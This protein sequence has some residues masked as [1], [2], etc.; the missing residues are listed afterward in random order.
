[1]T[2]PKYTLRFWGARGTVPSP[3]AETLRYGGNTSCLALALDD[4]EHLILDCGSGVR[5]FGMTLP[6]R[7]DNRPARFHGSSPG[8][9]LG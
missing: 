3:A 4:C 7:R 5:H 2:A 8:S 1:M 6:T 9:L